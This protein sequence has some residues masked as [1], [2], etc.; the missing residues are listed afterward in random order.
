MADTA[1][2]VPAEERQ[3]DIDIVDRKAEALAEQIKKSKHFIVFTG[4]G[5]STSAGIPD[6]R[7]TQGVWTLMAQGRQRPSA[8]NTLQAVPTATHMAL[9]ELQNRGILKY[10]VS[11]N[12]DALHRKSGI[13]PDKISE[14]H[15]N[16]NREYCKDC[17]KE[18]IRDFRAVASYEKTVYDHRTG[19][20][21]ARCGGALLDSI[22][23][24]GE[25]L[26]AEPLRLARSHAKKADLC[27]VLGSSLTVPPASG[28]PETVGARKT[29]KLAI[30]NLQDTPLDGLADQRIYSKA[31]KLMTRVMAKLD[32][33]IPQFILRRR[34]IVQMETTGGNRHQLKICGVDVDGTPMSFLRSVKLEQY[35]RRA[36]CIEPFTISFRSDLDI[37]TELELELEFM[38]NYGEPNLGIRYEY[39]GEAG[40]EILYLLEY[41]PQTGGWKTERQESQSIDENDKPT[42]RAKK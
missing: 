37:G 4:A 1:P 6:F 31:D 8:V 25:Y 26:P 11:Q 10:L 27:L 2:E 22:V 42:R 17:G 5:I 9:V 15:G 40:A 29:A 21:C 20:K 16:N 32:I 14:L 33:P 23:N 41:D 30:C 18:Y 12:C 7:G 3:E 36:A 28:I 19:R 39:T 24:F 13:L 35:C 38:G 34:L